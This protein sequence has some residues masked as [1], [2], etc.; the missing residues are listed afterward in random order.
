MLTVTPAIW[1]SSGKVHPLGGAVFLNL[2]NHP[3]DGWPDEQVAAA[4]AVAPRLVDMPFPDVDPHLDEDGMET[5]VEKLLSR[6]PRDTTAAMVQGEFTLSFRL[7]QALEATGVRCFAATTERR[8]VE[9][10]R[11]KHSRFGFV[12]LRRYR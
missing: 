10:P 11:G 5:L 6:V 7:V 1:P 4:S 2:S 8:V 3:S 9:S 12:Q